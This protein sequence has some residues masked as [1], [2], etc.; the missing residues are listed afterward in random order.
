MDL[1]LHYLFLIQTKMLQ[2]V[3]GQLCFSGQCSEIQPLPSERA[4]ADFQQAS[5]LR[6][7]AAVCSCEESTLQA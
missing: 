3:S 5:V 6:H 7:E 1:N 2:V 4:G